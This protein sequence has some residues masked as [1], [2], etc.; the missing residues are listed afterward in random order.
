M[1]KDIFKYLGT[2]IFGFGCGIGASYLYNKKKTELDEV[3][4]IAEPDD[5]SDFEFLEHVKENWDDMNEVIDAMQYRPIYEDRPS[6]AP[7]KEEKMKE[8]PYVIKPEDFGMLDYED[9][10]LTYYSDGVLADDHDDKVEFVEQ[11]VGTEWRRE[12]ERGE[13]VVYVRNDARKCDYEIALDFR[14]YTDIVDEHP[15][16]LHNIL[17]SA[18]AQMIEDEDE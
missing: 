14:T 9:I 2:F 11:V 15:Y 3:M 10:C 5:S 7:T 1:N 12:F 18:T 4:D 16:L 17:D 13:T 6:F 8:I